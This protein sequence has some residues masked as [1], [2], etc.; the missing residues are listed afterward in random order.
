MII[1]FDLDGTLLKSD[2]TMSPFTLDTLKLMKK[3]ENVNF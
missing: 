2:N 1:A 3:L